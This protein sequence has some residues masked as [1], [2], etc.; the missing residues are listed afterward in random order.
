MYFGFAGGTLP[1]TLTAF[2]GEAEGSQLLF[3]N[4]NAGKYGMNLLNSAG[5]LVMTRFIQV[6]SSAS[7][8]EMVQLPGALSA[9]TYLVAEH[10]ILI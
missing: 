10:R 2:T 9:G 1:L 5:Q 7:Y 4:M 8:N 6:P 3:R